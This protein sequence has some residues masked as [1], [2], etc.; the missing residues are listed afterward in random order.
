MISLEES[1]EHEV[2]GMVEFDFSADKIIRL[3]NKLLKR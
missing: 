3:V 1:I 2:Q